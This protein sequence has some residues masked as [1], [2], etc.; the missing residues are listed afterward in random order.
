VRAF[1]D[2]A[3]YNAYVLSRLGRSRPGAVYLHYTRA[4]DREL[5]IHRGS[6]DEKRVLPREAF[7]QY[8]RSFVGNPP[9]WLREGF[10]VYFS[11]LRYDEV[12]GR[13][14]YREN[15]AWLETVKNL[16]KK[17]PPL[18]SVLLADILGIPDNFIPA[19]WALVSFLMNNSDNSYY[20]TLGEVFL[21][22]DPVAPAGENAQY[23]AQ[24]IT[25]WMDF[26]RMRTDYQNY[27]INRK[28]F[29]DLLKNGQEAY[30]SK[31][32]ATA[33][34]WFSSALNLRSDH[35]AP[36]YYLGLINYQKQDYETAENYYRLSLEKGADKALI[37][38]ARGLNAASM[39]KNHDALV[40]LRQAVLA[41]PQAY[42]EK[43][44]ALIK[45]LQ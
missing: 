22:L 23:A 45:K 27:F 28:T 4:E 10:A 13:L 14:E 40:F 34:E 31:D 15:L 29:N 9:A 43:A 41:N 3:S 1:K 26:E 37:N 11:N 17:A 30:N 16:D 19:S 6:P 44:D 25:G 42:K 39:G 2:E 18:E 5:V 24:R 21:T 38:Y 35:H 32:Y 33:D 7:L 8:V 20:R 12:L 36:Y